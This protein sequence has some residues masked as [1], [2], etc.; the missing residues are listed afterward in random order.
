MESPWQPMTTAPKD[1]RHILLLTGNDEIVQG[2]W[3]AEVRN[4]YA[5]SAGFTGEKMGDW[6]SNYVQD[7]GRS[8]RLFCGD[9][10]R[11]W[12]PIPPPPADLGSPAYGGEWSKEFDELFHS[13]PQ[14][15]GLT[16]SDLKDPFPNRPD[17]RLGEHG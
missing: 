16:I 12:M 2:W 15:V 17:W 5:D 9:M 4:F 1:G 14:P 6:V 13:R 3:N 7:D 11:N 8:R 10:P